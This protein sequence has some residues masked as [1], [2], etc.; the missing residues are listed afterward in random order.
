MKWEYIDF[1]NAVFNAPG[2]FFSTEEQR[3]IHYTKNGD[4]H[5][6]PIPSHLLSMML[7]IKEITEGNQYA[8]SLHPTK[9]LSNNTIA[10]AISSYKPRSNPEIKLNLS[11]MLL[12]KHN[13]SFED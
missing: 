5:S 12:T 6:T 7:E 3:E 8:L 13:F 11:K 9:P 10:K 2:W 4:A 1:E